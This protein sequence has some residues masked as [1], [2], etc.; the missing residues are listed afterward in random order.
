MSSMLLVAMTPSGDQP[1]MSPTSLPP[2]PS[3]CTQH[4]ASSSSGCSRMPL[5]AATPTDP[6]AHWTTR[7]LMIEFPSVSR[8]AD[9]VD[10]VG[11]PGPDGL[12]VVF[13]DAGA[14]NLV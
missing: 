1:M 10:I 14:G 9:L 6:V 8:F 3:E 13:T 12:L 5:I 4:P 2:L 7:R 11:V